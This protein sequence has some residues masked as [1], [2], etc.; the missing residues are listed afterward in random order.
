MAKQYYFSIT[1]FEPYDDDEEDDGN[2]KEGLCVTISPKYY[3][4]AEECCY[5]QH[6][7]AEI[8]P[9]IGQL[10]FILSEDSECQFTVWDLCKVPGL[11]PVSQIKYV[12]QELKKLGFIEFDFESIL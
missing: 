12:T 7:A 8:D 2:D 5:D 10:P 6:I 9:I 11:I 1:P 4:D 3:T